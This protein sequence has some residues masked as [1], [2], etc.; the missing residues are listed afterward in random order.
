MHTEEPA[1]VSSNGIDGDH[2]SGTLL[3]R[4]E[5]PDVKAVVSLLLSLA[6]SVTSAPFGKLG[7]L[8]TC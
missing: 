4:V 2:E 6:N 1:A 5:V 7:M 3:V 8:L